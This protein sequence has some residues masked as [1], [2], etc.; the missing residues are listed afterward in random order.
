M[1]PGSSRSSARPTKLVLVFLSVFLCVHPW[2]QPAAFPAQQEATW[3]NR[4]TYA[5]GIVPRG[6]NPLL[7]RAG[8]N[9]V[10]SV[11]LSRLLRPDHEGG[12]E[13]DLAESWTVS[14][15]GR[16]YEFRLRRGVT[17]HDGAPFSADDVLFTWEKLFDPKTE[18]TLDLNQ[19]S[20][21]KSHKKDAHTFVFVLKAP[22]SGF[23]AALTEIPILPAHRLREADINGDAFNRAMIGTGPYKLVSTTENRE[24][25]LARHETHHHGRPAFDEMLIRVIADDDARAR[26]VADGLADLAHVKPPHVEMLR[27]TGRTLFRMRTG[28]WRAMP[29]NL[30]R[31]ALQDIHVRQAIDLAIDREAIV[32]E[33][34]QGYGQAAYSPIPPASWAFTPA[35]N[36]KRHDPAR[37]RDLLRRAGW[38]RPVRFDRVGSGPSCLYDAVHKDGQVLELQLIVWKDE[39]FR[40]TAAHLI[41]RHLMEVGFCVQLHLVDGTTYNRLA[42]NMGTEYD[43]YIGGWGG[44]LDPGDNLYKKYHS[45]G[46][47][48]RTGYSNPKV[49][50]LLEEARRNTD[51]KKAIPLYE[52]IVALVT[53]DAVFLPLAYPDYLFAARAE[54]A[55]IEDYTLDSWYEF[56]KYAAEWKKK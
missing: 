5:A 47:Q 9:E 56:T 49:D 26:A 14:P 51:R 46:S 21:A 15:D 33:A 35:M 30:R 4:L 29:L 53:K 52:K 17:W 39:F 41:Q 54:L 38:K 23:P 40:R 31:P 45:K 3:P 27:A 32:R 25:L 11:V 34:L 50:K 36:A 24:F 42:E 28:A 12:I 43:G 8:W 48:N 13:G 55:G 6:M 18:T 44:L 37:A 10:S 1:S 20:L 22:D 7:D 2:I 19:A 16:V